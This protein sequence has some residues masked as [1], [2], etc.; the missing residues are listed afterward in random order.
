M[1]LSVISNLHQPG[2]LIGAAF[3]GETLTVIQIQ[4]AIYS[5][6]VCLKL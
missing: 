2:I 3:S 4:R 6:I 1:T 5:K